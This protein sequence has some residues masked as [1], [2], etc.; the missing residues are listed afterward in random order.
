MPQEAAMSTNHHTSRL[1]AIALIA[2]LL[3]A[4]LAAPGSLPALVRHLAATYGD[5]GAV[6]PDNLF[7]V[8]ELLLP[9]PPALAPSDRSRYVPLT[10]PARAL[11]TRSTSHVG[12]AE[13]V[14]PYAAQAI[15]EMP[16]LGAGGVPASGRVA[17]SG[18]FS[19]CTCEAIAKPMP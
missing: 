13:L 10:V 18:R 11:D 2:L 3:G 16:M 8:G 12:P 9:D 19:A 7:G 17:M 5:L 4:G 14:G 15:I 6:G 1:F